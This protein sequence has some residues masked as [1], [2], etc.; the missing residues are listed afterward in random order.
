MLAAITPAI[1][2][3]LRAKGLRVREYRIPPNGSVNC[4]VAPADDLVIG[5]MEAPL[6][7]VSRVD[8][9]VL[10]E[11][12]IRLADIPFDAESGEV[13]LA[14]SIAHL[15]TLF[16]HREVVRLVAVEAGEERVP[17]EYTFNHSAG[18]T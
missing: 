18:G 7:G 9:I 16:A 17:E 10:Y 1:V 14:P 2:D 6:R 4:S 15:R 11:G 8:A 3:R 12:Q 5:R 13:V